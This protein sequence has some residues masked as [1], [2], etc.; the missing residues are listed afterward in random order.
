MFAGLTCMLS[1][2]EQVRALHSLYSK[3]G[4]FSVRLPVCCEMRLTLGR[5]QNS[6]TPSGRLSLTAHYC[7]PRVHSGH[8]WRPE[9]A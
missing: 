1:P 7:A 6:L 5:G 8:G 4:I 2:K 3:T 9:V